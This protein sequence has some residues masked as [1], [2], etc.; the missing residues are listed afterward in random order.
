MEKLQDLISNGMITIHKIWIVIK[1]FL[2]PRFFY[3]V[4]IYWFL[5]FYHGFLT[6]SNLDPYIQISDKFILPLV[7]DAIY[8]GT[9]LSVVLIAIVIILFGLKTFKFYTEQKTS[10]FFL[11]ILHFTIFGLFTAEF[12]QFWKDLIWIIGMS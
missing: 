4:Y 2:N 6:F 9:K 12:N 5:I 11:A 3:F 7:P 8:V 10:L 1:N